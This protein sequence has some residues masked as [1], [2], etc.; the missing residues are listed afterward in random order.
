MALLCVFVVV[1]ILLAFL[2]FYFSFGA[3]QPT[4]SVGSSQ[5]KSGE[6]EYHW[7]IVPVSLKCFFPVI[8]SNMCQDTRQAEQTKWN[9]FRWNEFNISN[10]K[11]LNSF[12]SLTAASFVCSSHRYVHVEYHG[13]ETMKTTNRGPFDYIV[14]KG[15]VPTQQKKN[16]TFEYRLSFHT[17]PLYCLC[18][19]RF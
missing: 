12:V 5:Q 6:R 3:S 1:I 2:A 8:Y 10:E 19:I 14:S 17:T 4:N 11:R 7:H 18:I 13:P 9:N 16:I 15:S